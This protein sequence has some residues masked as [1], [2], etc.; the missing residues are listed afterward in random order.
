MAAARTETATA[1]RGMIN[2]GTLSMVRNAALLRV[3]LKA[4]TAP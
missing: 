1:T 3:E 2:R 4:A